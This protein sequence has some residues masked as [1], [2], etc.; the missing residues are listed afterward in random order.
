MRTIRLKLMNYGAGP[1]WEIGG[2]GTD[3]NNQRRWH[4]FIKDAGVI[5]FS[6]VL[7][8]APTPLGQDQQ[9]PFRNQFI[10]LQSASCPRI[11]FRRVILGS[12]LIS[13]QLSRRNSISVCAQVIW[14][15]AA[16]SRVEWR[17]TQKGEAAGSYRNSISG[18]DSLSSRPD[19]I[20]FYK[21]L[22]MIKKNKIWAVFLLLL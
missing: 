1:P 13:A 15:W 9:H 19:G 14:W 12:S 17:L 22:K 18:E 2:G 10:I 21:V 4:K 6:K 3:N 7:H 11:H 20:E 16:E 8:R 5:V